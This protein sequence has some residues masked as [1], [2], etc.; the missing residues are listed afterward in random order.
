MKTVFTHSL[1]RRPTSLLVRPRSTVFLTFLVASAL[2]LA[3]FTSVISATSASAH[4]ELVKITPAPNAQLSTV[5][6]RVVLEFDEPVSTSFA[7]VV[8]TTAAGIS[9]TSG[10]PVAVGAKVTQALSPHLSAGTY[11]VAFRV[12][13]ADGHPVSGESGFTLTPAPRT[14]PATSA[15][16]TSSP[17]TPS[18]AVG[19]TTPPRGPKAVPSGGL[20]RPT[21]AIAGAVGLV[22][23]GAGV[24]LWLRR[25]P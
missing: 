15:P 20:S 17:A 5:P 12:V 8:V 1:W 6:K 18:V 2:G 3:L 22:S 24:L 21:M 9:V 16:S 14:S 19:H 4:A 7:T 13:S 23:L 10:K 11:R 25:R